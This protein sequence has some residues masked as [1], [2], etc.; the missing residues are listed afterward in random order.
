MH[1]AKNIT[2]QCSK[3]NASSSKIILSKHVASEW[4][5]ERVRERE[6]E[7]EREREREEREREA[8]RQTDTETDRQ[9]EAEPQRE[10]DR[11][12][13][14]QTQREIK[15]ELETDT[16]NHHLYNKNGHTP[17]TNK[18][19]TFSCHVMSHPGKSRMVVWDRHTISKKG[20]ITFCS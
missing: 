7:K 19:V 15:S 2:I 13:D 14:R 16:E 3:Y 17:N 8:D 4:E 18:N 20:W 6:G 11:P 1:K 5:R 10:T 12:K 9:R